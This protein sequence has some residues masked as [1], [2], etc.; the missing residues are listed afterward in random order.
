MKYFHGSAN[1]RNITA[2]PD[3]GAKDLA[4]G[5]GVPVKVE[6]QSGGDAVIYDLNEVEKANPTL[7]DNNGNYEFGV[8]DGIYKI[9]IGTGSQQVTLENVEIAQ[10]SASTVKAYGVDAPDGQTVINVPDAPTGLIVVKDGVTQEQGDDLYPKDF[11]YNSATGNVTFTD[12]FTGNERIFFIYGT[13]IPSGSELPS[14]MILRG[15]VTYE[16]FDVDLTGVEPADAKIIAAHN[17][18]N[19][20]NLPVKQNSG[21]VYWQNQSVT[22]QTST[23][24]SGMILRVDANSGTPDLNYSQPSMYQISSNKDITLL[25]AAAITDLNTNYQKYFTKYSQRL[26]TEYFE[27]YSGRYVEIYSDLLEVNRNGNPVQAQYAREQT[28]ISRR[29]QLESPIYHDLRGRITEIRVYPR[30]DFRLEF[31]A[32][33]L[34]INNTPSFNLIT[35]RRSLTTIEGLIIQEESGVWP[36]NIR[37]I[38]EIYNCADVQVRDFDALSQPIGTTN[39]GAVYM[40]VASD[41]LR[42]KMYRI[43]SNGGLSAFASNY[44]RDAIFKD[45]NMNR[46]DCHWGGYDILIDG[47]TTTN[48]G[49]SIGGG[50]ILRVTNHTHK[51]TGPVSSPYGEVFVQGLVELREDY[52]CIF[53]GTI[54]VDGARFVIDQNFDFDLPGRDLTYSVVKAKPISP[55]SDWG[56]VSQRGKRIEVRNVTIEFNNIMAT[57]DTS[58]KLIAVNYFQQVSGQAIFP[59]E[60]IVEN[61]STVNEPSDFAVIAYNPPN[62]MHPNNKA[63]Y[64]APSPQDGDYNQKVTVRDIICS[65]RIVNRRAELGLVLFNQNWGQTTT[66]YPDYTADENAIRPKIVIENCEFASVAIAVVGRCYMRGTRISQLQSTMSGVSPFKPTAEQIYIRIEDCDINLISSLDNANSY[67]QNERVYAFNCRFGDA[68]EID[69]STHA[70]L[71]A[72]SYRGRGNVVSARTTVWTTTTPLLFDG[73]NGYIQGS[74][75]PVGSVTPEFI[76]QQYKDTTASNTTGLY[77]STGTTSADWSD[78]G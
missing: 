44:V 61:I 29:G 8:D 30:E 59:K 55:Q 50:G 37:E 21:V 23:D 45:N 46:I 51:Q 42:L 64:A 5:I 26:P 70:S 38:V 65:P 56:V 13:V 68:T 73:E 41:V 78:I 19:A 71:I 12:T 18:A 4:A 34:V 25:D 2:D 66:T 32:P 10:V 16:D 67:E 54:V 60:I 22:V 53:D 11:T 24:L 14:T 69:G 74:G 52:G 36:S 28:S 58:F 43:R 48:M 39:A 9:I 75:S 49:I 6:F 17:Y 7:T 76:G 15:Y 3:T 57:L 33:K 77:M 72:D 31:K 63:M 20:N 40:T 1:L 62:Y 27:E 47:C 35:C